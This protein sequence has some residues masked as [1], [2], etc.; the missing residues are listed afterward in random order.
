MRVRVLQRFLWVCF[1]ALA[2][3][4]GPAQC[5]AALEVTDRTCLVLSVGGTSGMAL[6]GAVDELT[7]AG[8]RFDCVYGN[9]AGALVGALYASAP[10]EPVAPRLRDYMVEYRQITEGEVV[11]QAGFGALLGLAMFGPLAALGGAVVG[12]DSV[13]PRELE[14]ARLVLERHLGATRLDALPVQFTTEFLEIQG[15]G[16]RVRE[17]PGSMS[18]SEAVTTSI[19]NPLLFTDIVLE[20]GLHMDPGMDRLSAIPAL[21]ACR[22]YQASNLLVLNATADEIFSYPGMPCRVR[23]VRVDVGLAFDHADLFRGGRA[24][25]TL[26]A[27]GR[28]DVAENLGRIEPL[29]ASNV[30]PIR[31]VAHAANTA[32]EMHSPNGQLAARMYY[33]SHFFGPNTVEFQVQEGMGAAWQRVRAYALSGPASRSEFVVWWAADGRL[34]YHRRYGELLENNEVVVYEA[35]GGQL[36]PQLAW[37]GRRAAAPS[38]HVDPNGGR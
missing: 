26:M 16:A 30:A 28:A 4:S 25:Q 32:G 12:A 3:C 13:N 38:W 35:I 2:A 33:E 10:N 34:V 19:A 27:Y 14:R 20:S 31:T 18:L 6:A 21:L 7:A 17:A 37:A 22:R 11:G 9:S 5:P 1:C 36:R 24:F 15:D 23:E 29:R 8:M